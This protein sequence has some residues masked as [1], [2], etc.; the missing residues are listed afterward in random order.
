MWQ[1]NGVFFEVGI[2]FLNVISL[3][4]GVEILH[5][6]QLSPEV[7]I[8]CNVSSTFEEVL[9]NI[10]DYN[11]LELKFISSNQLTTI[12]FVKFFIKFSKNKRLL[13][14][15]KYFIFSVLTIINRK[16]GLK[17]ILFSRR[18]WVH[19]THINRFQVSDGFIFTP[20]AK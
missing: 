7:L 9:R 19:K 1:W 8:Y 5:K 14:L 13:I 2:T 10:T 18:M 15:E 16:F 20:L 11:C 17:Q 6:N 12:D 4:S 3:N